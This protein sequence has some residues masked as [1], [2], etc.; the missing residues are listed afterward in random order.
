MDRKR[1]EALEAALRELIDN[2]HIDPLAFS[3]AEIRALRA[4]MADGR[5]QEVLR[6]YDTLSTM[7]AVGKWAFRGVL[8]LAA[9]AVAWRELR[10][11]WPPI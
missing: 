8:A 11:L 9:L 4:L 3:E 7:G 10:H 6:L 1:A 5:L 2:E